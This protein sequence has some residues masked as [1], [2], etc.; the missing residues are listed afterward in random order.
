MR[1]NSIVHTSKYE[2]VIDFADWTLQNHHP[3]DQYEWSWMLVMQAIKT[4]LSYRYAAL[5]HKNESGSKH[6]DQ[7]LRDLLRIMLKSHRISAKEK[8]IH[9]IMYRF[10]AVYR[11]FRIKDDPSLLNWEESIENQPV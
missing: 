10:P 11:R 7:V 6:A 9:L 8:A 3:N 5:L 2:T 4:A 1:D